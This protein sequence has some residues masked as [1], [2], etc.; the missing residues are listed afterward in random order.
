MSA[1]PKPGGNGGLAGG[2]R[3]SPREHVHT[4]R[5]GPWRPWPQ[6]G[7]AFCLIPAGSRAAPARGAP[8][9][10][11]SRPRLGARGLWGPLAFERGPRRPCAGVAGGYGPAWNVAHPR[12]AGPCRRHAPDRARMAADYE[13]AYPCCC[14]S[15]AD[16]P[17]SRP[18]FWAVSCLA[19]TTRRGRPLLIHSLARRRAP[20]RLSRPSLPSRAS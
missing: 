4:G 9:R 18:L 1:R 17:A 10:G 5:A 3:P 14:C 7:P 13:P 6:A 2:P 15:P 8:P 20:P 11:L 12:P 16:G 19:H